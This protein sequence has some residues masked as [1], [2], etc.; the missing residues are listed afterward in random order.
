VL[1]LASELT[2]GR[3]RAAAKAIA[4]TLDPAPLAVRH[5]DARTKRQVTVRDVED[6]MS[7]V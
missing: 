7:E 4:E 6:G 3:L 2:V 5:E 1:D